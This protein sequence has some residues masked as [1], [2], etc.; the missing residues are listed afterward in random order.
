M[1]KKKV[2]II[3]AGIGGLTAGAL[4]LKKGFCVDIFEKESIV[5]GRAISLEMS[6]QTFESYKQILAKFNSA[7]VFSDP[8]LQ[9]L[10]KNNKF[11]GY[12]LDLGFHMIGSGIV[13]KL[14]EILMEY[15]ENI[16]MYKSR[17]Y[18]QKNNHFG[19]FA[20]TAD[21]LA[22]LPN[23]TRL[24]LSSEKTMKELDTVPMTETIKKYGIGKMKIVLEVNSRLISTINNLDLISTGEIFRTQKDMKLGGV[25]YPKDGLRKISQTLATYIE[26]NGG[27]IHL[28]SPVTKILIKNKKAEGVIV[29]NQEYLFDIVLS[30]ILVQNLFT[31]ADEH[32]FPEQY[33]TDL[34]ALEGTG[35]L[36]AY[37]SLN[38]INPQLLGKSFIFIERNIGVDGND[39]V[40]MIDFISAKPE[41][42]LAPQSQ[43][44]IQSYIICTPKEA[45]DK[46]ILTTLKE[47]LD[48]NLE[49]IIPHYQAQLNW[50]IYPS[51]WHLD[52]VAKTLMNTK[53]DIQ[54]PVEN[55]YL[56]GD[57]VKAPGI[58][59]NC[60]INSAR[61][62][63][64]MLSSPI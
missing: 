19:Y 17:L 6:S 43:H 36:C 7:I 22:M 62:I 35:S 29:A 50:A 37:Y 13:V 5:G 28:S 58:G 61:I 26:K 21:K 16:T 34:K 55:L 56:I 47:A 52:G 8:P 9:D 42:G 60:A 53:P 33:V 27:K 49:R 3:G 32:Q 46:K 64:E 23:I 4:L 39:A 54:T 25:N 20:T 15:F 31:I 10:F 44:L 30:N 40:G 48:K 14:R 59:I 2:C 63:Q 57:C 45:R 12:T 11:Q 1:K 38:Q 18:E 51:I 24:L 41:T